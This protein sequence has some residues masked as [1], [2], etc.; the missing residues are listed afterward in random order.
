[1][2]CCANR[3]RARVTGKGHCLGERDR[4]EVYSLGYWY[5]KPC[6]V[7]LWQLCCCIPQ[8]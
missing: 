7:K 5:Y 4:E 3:A 2:N 1:M 6:M 8:L